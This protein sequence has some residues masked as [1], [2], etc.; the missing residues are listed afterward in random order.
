MR[1]KICTRCKIEKSIRCFG[2]RK[3]R[4]K[5][6]AKARTV[7]QRQSHCKECQKEIARKRRKSKPKICEKACRRINLKRNHGIEV[8][9]YNKMLTEQSGKCKICGTTDPG[10]GRK[11]LVVDHNHETGEIRGLLCYLCNIGLG[12]FQD[13]KESLKKAVLYLSTR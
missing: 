5:G 7:D 12:C 1:K 13:D 10:N 11:Y 8:E 4:R 2:K 9:D 3:P 6:L